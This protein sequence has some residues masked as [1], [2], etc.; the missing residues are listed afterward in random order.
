MEILLFFLRDFSMIVI[1]AIDLKGGRCVRLLQGDFDRATVYADDPVMMASTWK[2]RGAERL[3][4][5]DLDGSL[6]GIPRHVAVIREIVAETGLPV[7]VGGGIRTMKTLETY[8]RI[9]VRWVILGTSALLDPSFVHEAC[10]MFPNQ[11]ILGIDAAGGRIAVRGWTERTEE[12]ATA[13]ALRFVED[14]PAALVY[15]DIARDGMETGVNVEATG[16]LAEM[17]GIPVIASGGVSGIRDI[18]RLQPLEKRGVV[19]V[20]VGKALYTGALSLTGAI[21]CAREKDEKGNA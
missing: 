3:H 11:V 19:G 10:H 16:E 21:E 6:A 4:V 2:R 15:T 5:V 8:L 18:K 14:K 12:A 7:Q 1:P 17:V 9:G 13:L 20:I